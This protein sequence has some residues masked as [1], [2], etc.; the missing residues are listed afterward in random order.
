MGHLATQPETK[1][2][3]GG[4]TVTTFS[5]ATNRD[6]VTKE[7]EAKSAADFHKVVA[8]RGLGKACA[9]FL[10]KGASVYVEGYLANNKF[11][12]K[13]GKNR[14]YTEIVADVVNFINIKK[15]K[16]VEEVRMVE[17]EPALA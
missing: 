6:W 12:D 10:K 4:H 3:T 14:K 7:G 16:D 11:Q 8:W 17:M 9:D 15:V 2:T 13:E 1:M 5:L